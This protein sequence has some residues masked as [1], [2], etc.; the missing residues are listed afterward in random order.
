MFP[1]SPPFTSLS[2]G[3]LLDVP[4][5]L[6]R[7]LEAALESAQCPLRGLSADVTQLINGDYIWRRSR[8]TVRLPL[9][10][11][12]WAFFHEALN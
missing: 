2:V 12:A 10:L 1:P 7:D 4:L 9:V 6:R 3:P 5:Q 8:G 11:G